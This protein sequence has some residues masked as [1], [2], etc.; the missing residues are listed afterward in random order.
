MGVD[1]YG[2]FQKQ[3]DGRWVDVESAD[4]GPRHYELFAWLGSGSI[5]RMGTCSIPSLA[6]LRGL[7]EDFEVV[8]GS[9]HPTPLPKRQDD[10]F[11]RW[12]HPF[13]PGCLWIGDWNFSWLLSGE[14]LRSR[15]PRMRR[16]V[17]V[18]DAEYADWDGKADS[19]PWLWA[20]NQFGHA[21]GLPDRLTPA[22][23]GMV[24]EW[25]YDFREDFSHFVGEIKRLEDLHG[26]VR[27]VFGFA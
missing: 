12:S 2:V 19:A 23:G 14:I 13:Y 15:A 18:S 27:F 5:D 21:V 20:S 25:D 4:V 3:V 22:P 1:I 17:L 24:A 26:E 10:P 9:N 6:P 16:T 8:D 7:P 11:Y